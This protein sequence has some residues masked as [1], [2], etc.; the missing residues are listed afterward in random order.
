MTT[1][2]LCAADV[3]APSPVAPRRQPRQSPFCCFHGSG[4]PK[5]AHPADASPR[6]EPSVQMP[7][8]SSMR[9]PSGT[10]PA[11]SLPGCLSP[12]GTMMVLSSPPPRRSHPSGFLFRFT[13]EIGTASLLFLCSFLTARGPLELEAPP[14]LWSYR[15]C[16]AYKGHTGQA[17]N[18]LEQNPSNVIGTGNR[19]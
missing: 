8:A 1:M 16:L 18:G 12:A 6:I 7:S 4:S 14:V 3:I 11:N 10:P 19:Y 5:N 2:H 15:H 9:E 17:A 13:P